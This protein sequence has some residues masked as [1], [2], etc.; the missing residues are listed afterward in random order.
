MVSDTR[1]CSSF[2]EKNENETKM[3]MKMKMMMMMMMMEE[4]ST[5]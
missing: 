5:D 2:A 1:F 4:Y 3:K